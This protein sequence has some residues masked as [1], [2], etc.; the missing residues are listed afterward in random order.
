MVRRNASAKPH[1]S[2]FS[3]RRRPSRSTTVFTA[4]NACAS[5]DNSSSN[6]TTACLQGWVMF[7]PANPIRSAASSRSGKASAPSPSRSRL[8][9][10]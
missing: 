8:M 5:G 7:S 9:F 6:G 2:V 10:W 3:P 1:Q 4:P